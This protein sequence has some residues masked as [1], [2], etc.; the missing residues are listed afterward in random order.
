MIEQD[1]KII[2]SPLSRRVAKDGITVRVSI[3]T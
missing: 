1:P 3:T 2:D